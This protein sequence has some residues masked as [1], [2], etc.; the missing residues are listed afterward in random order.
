M[1][2]VLKNLFL[3]LTLISGFIGCGSSSSNDDNDENP[4]NKTYTITSS[5]WIY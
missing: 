1:K 2:N 4:S 5:R 3:G